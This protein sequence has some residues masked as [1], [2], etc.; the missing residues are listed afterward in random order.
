MWQQKLCVI[1]CISVF[2][3]IP[4][5]TLPSLILQTLSHSAS[6]S[7]QHTTPGKITEHFWKITRGS[8]R[9]DLFLF[10]LCKEVQVPAVC[11]LPDFP[12]PEC[13]SPFFCSPALHGFSF[14]HASPFHTFPLPTLPF[15]CSNPSHKQTRIL[16]LSEAETGYLFRH[17]EYWPLPFLMSFPSSSCTPFTK[18]PSR[19]NK[20]ANGCAL[21]KPAI[22]NCG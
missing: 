7:C 12:F 11:Q 8:R 1:H 20:D 14:S 21:G 16:P 19:P 18:A 22:N 5:V 10:S 9:E 6:A 13:P 3:D 2:I 15:A 4:A 17:I